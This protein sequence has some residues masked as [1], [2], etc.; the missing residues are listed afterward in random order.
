MRRIDRQSEEEDSVVRLTTLENPLEHTE[1]AHSISQF[2][3]ISQ[4][5]RSGTA[6]AEPCWNSNVMYL[7]AALMGQVLIPTPRPGSAKKISSFRPRWGDRRRQFLTMVPGLMHSLEDLG[8]ENLDI[9]AQSAEFLLIR[10]TPSFQSSPPVP[11]DDLP[12]LEIS[13][14]CDGNDRTT[15][16]RDVRLVS[17]TEL[18]VLLP[19]NTMDLR[20]VRQTCVYS[21]EGSLDTEIE[22]FVHV[23][24]LDIWGQDRLKTPTELNISIPPHALRETLEER[25]TKDLKKETVKYT[26]SG[27][28]H[29]CKIEVPYHQPGSWANLTYTSIEA[30]K[31]G[32]RRDELALTQSRL[33]KDAPASAVLQQQ[34]TNAG[35]ATIPTDVDDEKYSAS[36]LCKANAL[37]QMLETPPDSSGD[38]LSRPGTGMGKGIRKVNRVAKSLQRKFHK[39]NKSLLRRHGIRKL[40]NFRISKRYL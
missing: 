26:F 29:R 17:K 10:L 14:F 40:D 5:E 16:I 12:D 8:M 6:R 31:F 21:K 28:E 39:N 13:I 7:D 15:S 38:N 19:Q 32:G 27:L 30:G 2:F 11:L 24:N 1:I 37:I 18:D 33:P 20:F 36:I 25:P 35:T 34:Q 3:A 22:R 23:S 4:R 9:N